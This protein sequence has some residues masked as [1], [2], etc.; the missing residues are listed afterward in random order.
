[1]RTCLTLAMTLVAACKLPTSQS[2]GGEVD[3]GVEVDGRTDDLDAGGPNADADADA[4]ADAAIEVDASI[5]APAPDV[6]APAFVGSTPATGTPVWLQAPITLEFDED[7]ASITGT[8]VTATLGGQ[9]VN[10]T[11]AKTGPRTLQIEL[12]AAARG[13]GALELHIELDVEDA[14]GNANTTPIDLALQAPAWS[15]VPVDRGTAVSAP[16]YAIASDGRV[17][18]A[19]L[20]S[21]PSG[22]RAVVSELAGNSWRALGGGLGLADASSVSLTLDASGA[23]V[24]AVIDQ[25]TA[26][27]ARWTGSAWDDLASPGNGSYVA[28]ATPAGGAPIVAV[29]GSSVTVSELV[30]DS[31]QPLGASVA[32]PSGIA[33]EPALA[34]PAAD[35]AV[36]GWIG[37]DAEIRVHRFSGGTWTAFAPLTA[38]SGSRMSLAARGT[39]VAI[40]YD[41]WAGSYGIL[42]AMAAGGAT[43]FT[44]L[45]KPLDIDI[46]GDARAP[47]I[48][49]D[50]SGA[51]IVAWAE[52]VEMAQ[53]GAVAR[54]SGSAWTIVGGV[55]WLASATSAPSGARLL[56]G[57][58]NA[59][60][61]ATLA[62]G[63][64]HL[65]RFNG[66][67]TA[68][69]GIATRAPLT[70]CS[71]SASAPPALLSQTGCFDLGT[72]K[73]PTAHAGLIPYDLVSEL[74]SDGARKRRWIALPSGG[75]MPLASNGSWIPPAGAFLIKEFA[76]ET[77]PGNPAT[78]RPVETRFMVNDATNGW[79]GFTYRWNTAGTDAT[80]LDQ[81]QT[82]AWTLD[83]GTQH[84]HLYPSRGHCRSCHY[85]GVGPVLGLRPEQLARWN[86]YN[87]T[88]ADQLTTLSSL[89]VTAQASPPA[90]TSPHDPSATWERR[91]RGYLAANCSHCHNP[92]YITIKDLRFAT[93]LAST[94]LCESIVAGDPDSSVVYQRVT[95]RPGMPPLGTLAVD[96]LARELLGTW[97]ANMTSCP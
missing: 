46:N 64:V 37:N 22:R 40:A 35:A 11:I 55:T 36:I 21:T 45:G 8:T 53:R 63:D 74:W 48:A 18:A 28:L 52:L 30:G 42:A 73:R 88:I 43:T 13:V 20:V 17:I 89:G 67:R 68:A 23:P 61:V 26:Y 80:L 82:Y 77:T 91:T 97:I 25:G 34:A 51:P 33:G 6:T 71:F 66:P 10:A 24:V 87:G 39:T 27:A 1:M 44:Q 75:A 12:D 65:A 31:W 41:K 19:W 59:P 56:L 14:A 5:D 92:Q 3:A 47:A 60:V 38:S 54:W 94:K 85:P 86:D 84:T 93:P 96:P 69:P 15:T 76:L 9:A 50:S 58:G 62:A 7:L 72:P 29:F 90:F 78:R 4:D 83:N 81:S 95:S 49:L 79:L 70:G 2:G 57:P 32:V 16:S